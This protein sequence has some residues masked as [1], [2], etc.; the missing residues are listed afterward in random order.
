MSG[1]SW[2]KV[3]VS[4]ISRAMLLD[5]AEQFSS[6]VRSSWA[7][8]T[9]AKVLALVCLPCAEC[10]MTIQPS[11]TQLCWPASKPHLTTSVELLHATLSI[12][13]LWGNGLWRPW[14]LCASLVWGRLLAPSVLIWDNESLKSSHHL[15]ARDRMNWDKSA[16]RWH[17]MLMLPVISKST[18]CHTISLWKWGTHGMNTNTNTI[19]MIT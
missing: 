12:I 13:Q 14:E 8:N 7:L 19:Y 15:M 6:S 10:A 11:P 17:P 3:Y 18:V 2:A 9:V 5:L 4:E 1:A 16:N